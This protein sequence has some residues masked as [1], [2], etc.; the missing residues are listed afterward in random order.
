MK[1]SF[2]VQSRLYV[3]SPLPGHHVAFKPVLGKWFSPGDYCID[4]EKK[5]IE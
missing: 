1:N 3:S 5:Y 2:V 4:K